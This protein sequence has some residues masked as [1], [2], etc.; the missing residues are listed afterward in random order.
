MISFRITIWV[1]LHRGLSNLTMK[2]LLFVVVIG[3][4]LVW[5]V[6]LVFKSGLALEDSLDSQNQF[7]Y[8]LN[9][10][11]GSGSIVFCDGDRS[12]VHIDVYFLHL[13][14]DVEE[15]GLGKSSFVVVCSLSFGF[16]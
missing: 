3:V 6:V 15:M 8:D 5:T 16:D 13:A 12:D 4:V 1:F 7:S 9:G 10:S 11:T 14:F 2:L